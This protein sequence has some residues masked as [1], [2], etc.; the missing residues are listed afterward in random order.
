MQAKLDS[1]RWRRLHSGVYAAFT[2][3]PDRAPVLWAAVLGAGPRAVLSH[4]TA[5]EL[6]G[7]LSAAHVRTGLST[8]RCREAVRWPR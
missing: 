4:Q 1:G 7:L 2:G 5:A 3:P 6:H 8:S